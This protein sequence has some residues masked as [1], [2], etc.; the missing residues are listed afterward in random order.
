MANPRKCDRMD[1]PIR[2]VIFDL[3][4]TTIDFGSRA[5]AGAFVELFRRHG[6]TLSQAEARG[7]MGM[8]KRD[9]IRALAQAPRIAQAWRDVHGSG[10]D[11]AMVDALYREFIPL[12]LEA[13][14]FY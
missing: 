5:P 1:T 3:A 12:Q 10:C 4:G 2:A 14:P 11:E 6:I 7:P 13:L 8:D 9:H